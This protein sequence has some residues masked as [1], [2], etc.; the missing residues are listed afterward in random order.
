MNYERL[1]NL[2][3]ELF[4]LSAEM[5][6]EFTANERELAEIVQMQ[7]KIRIATYYGFRI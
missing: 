2:A 3:F 6:A 5:I 7:K 4:R 1:K